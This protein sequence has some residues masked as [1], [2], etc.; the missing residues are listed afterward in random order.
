MGRKAIVWTFQVT[1]TWLRKGNFKR[2][3]ESLLIA[4]QNNAM[5]TNYVKTKNRPTMLK[6]KIDKIQQN[7]LHHHMLCDDGDETSNHIMQ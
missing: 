3:I 1:W 7:C 4:A 2:K 6:Q 5:Q